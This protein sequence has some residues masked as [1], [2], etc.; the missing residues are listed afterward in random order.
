MR[1]KTLAIPGLAFGVAGVG[2]GQAR[3][4]NAVGFFEVLAEASADEP[5]DS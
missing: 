5:D 4:R 2:W 1:R 3:K